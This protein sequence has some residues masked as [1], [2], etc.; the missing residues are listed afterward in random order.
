VGKPAVGE[1]VEPLVQEFPIS[2][3]ASVG[4]HSGQNFFGRDGMSQLVGKRTSGE[5]GAVELEGVQAAGPSDASK[6]RD[7][8][9]EQASRFLKQ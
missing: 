2:R 8:G 3:G 4:A 1:A 9:D 6:L 5:P 7:T